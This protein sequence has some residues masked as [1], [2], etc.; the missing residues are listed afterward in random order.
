MSTTTAVSSV[1]TWSVGKDGR[2]F[3]LEIFD[4]GTVSVLDLDAFERDIKGYHPTQRLVCRIL[5]CP[6]KTRHQTFINI[7]FEDYTTIRDLVEQMDQYPEEDPRLDETVEA[8]EEVLYGF[9][10]KM[11]TSGAVKGF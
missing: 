1:F 6:E 3:E 2:E 4:N 10:Y 11:P 8:I 9:L 7:D 5:N